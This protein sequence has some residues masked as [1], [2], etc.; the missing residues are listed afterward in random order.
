MKLWVVSGIVLLLSGPAVLLAQVPERGFFGDFSLIPGERFGTI[1]LGR[2]RKEVTAGM[3]QPFIGQ[4]VA[5]WPYLW[6]TPE[7]G[8]GRVDFWV[9]YALL[10]GSCSKTDRIFFAAAITVRESVNDHALLN[11]RVNSMKTPEGLSISMGLA[12]FTSLYGDPVLRLDFGNP[13][14]LLYLFSN[15]LALHVNPSVTPGPYVF[16]LGVYHLGI[17]KGESVTGTYIPFLGRAATVRTIVGRNPDETGV[18][19]EASTEFRGQETVHA[20]LVLDGLALLPRVGGVA[21]IVQRKLI[22]PRN[23]ELIQQKRYEVPAGTRTLVDHWE[24]PPRR[25]R[26]DYVVEFTVNRLTLPRVSFS[27]TP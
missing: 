6:N 9:N 15:G 20:T 7:P 18:P 12:P 24:I 19:R 17:C 8:L 16:A 26:G 21:V 22:S 23:E 11:Y 14:T 4:G 13:G 3:G 27:Y 1:V 10:L 25:F 2:T 5:R